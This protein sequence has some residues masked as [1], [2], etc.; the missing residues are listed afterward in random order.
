MHTTGAASGFGLATARK[1][2]EEGGKVIAADMNAS[3]LEKQFPQGSNPSIFAITANVTVS[4]DWEK[5]VSTAEEKF[6]G[7][8]IVSVTS[9]G[10]RLPSDNSC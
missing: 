9:S 8:D 2:V 6:G 1:F 3:A 7:L 5:L 10:R 4:S